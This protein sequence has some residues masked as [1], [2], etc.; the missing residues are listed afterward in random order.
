MSAGPNLH[1]ISCQCKRPWQD[2]SAAE[3]V[4]D[5]SH[6]VAATGAESASKLL[7]GQLAKIAEYAGPRG[8][9]STGERLSASD[10]EATRSMDLIRHAIV[11]IRFRRH[12]VALVG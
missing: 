6:L 2:L 8:E 7:H 4:P 12:V 5:D 10:A 9:L 3:T 11:L 1:G